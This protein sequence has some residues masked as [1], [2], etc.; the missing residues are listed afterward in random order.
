MS[1]QR[2]EEDGAGT[3]AVLGLVAAL[4]TVALGA[5]AL[6]SAVVAGHQ[7]AAAADLGALAGATV[8]ADGGDLAPGACAAA[9]RIARA[10]GAQITSCA[11]RGLEIWV[12]T[13]ASPSWPGL[14]VATAR[15]RAGPVGGG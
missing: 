15:A 9:E 5:W 1:R 3:V 6:L 4:L 13:A 2:P 8:L 12:G 10:N 11:V 14:G 7:A